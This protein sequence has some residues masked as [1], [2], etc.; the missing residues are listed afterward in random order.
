MS[1]KVGWASRPPFERSS[2]PMIHDFVVTTGGTPIPPKNVYEKLFA[3]RAATVRERSVLIT[4]F[5]G[6]DHSL[7]VAAR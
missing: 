3:Q 4:C 2:K 5:R 7:T 1:D 6:S